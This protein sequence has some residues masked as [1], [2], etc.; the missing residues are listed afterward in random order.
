MNIYISHSV[1]CAG[2]D[3]EG[4]FKGTSFQTG[5]RTSRF[6]D[7][8]KG[9]V[10]MLDWD[11]LEWEKRPDLIE[12]WHL[13]LVREN[14][15][16]VVMSMDLWHNNIHK[17]LQYADKLAKITNRVLIP[18]HHYSPE[19]RDYELAYPNANWF[20]KNKYPPHD[21]RELFKHILGGSPQSQIK[22][23]NTTQRDIWGHPMKFKKI[24]SIDGNQIFNMSIRTGKIW[25]PTKPYWRK[26]KD[27][28]TNEEI[29]KRSVH[30]LNNQF[31]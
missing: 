6:K 9:K 20:T 18:V 29:F 8:D 30:N 14:D 4:I 13:Q 28:M 23:L 16:D 3:M 24:E 11:Y 17:A 26:P 7:A 1:G 25:H 5:C 27:E 15:F 2:W 12:N 19:L 21:Y 31:L 22:L 10:K